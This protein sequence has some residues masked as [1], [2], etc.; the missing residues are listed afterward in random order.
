LIALKLS[1]CQTAYLDGSFATGKS[2]PNDFD[3]CYDLFD[4][5]P[6][7][8]DKVFFDFSNQRQRQKD[9]YGGEFFPAN[10]P[11]TPSDLRYL[12]FFQTNKHTQ[13]AKE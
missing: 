11:A 1:G 12:E 9:K 6:D 7:L 10:I 13:T 4:I 3:V 8:L 5:N 2:N